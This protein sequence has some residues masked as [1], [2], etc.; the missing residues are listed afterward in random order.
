MGIAIAHKNIG[1][2][3]V[4]AVVLRGGGY[5]RE[6]SGNLNIG[7]VSEQAGWSIGR[8][9]AIRELVDYMNE[10]DD[11]ISGH[12]KFWITGYSRG[13]AVANMT[14]NFMDCALDVVS[15]EATVESIVPDSD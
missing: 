8:N 5:G 12:P 11:E 14:A 2:K 6:G 15:G 13:A 9:K 3:S 1:G 10:Y 7:K 4:I